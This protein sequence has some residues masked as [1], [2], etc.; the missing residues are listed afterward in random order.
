MCC[1][2]VGLLVAMGGGFHIAHMDEASDG[3]V[4]VSVDMPSAKD[5]NDRLETL[6]NVLTAVGQAADSEKEEPHADDAAETNEMTEYHT[7]AGYTAI[8]GLDVFR[9]YITEQDYIP[10]SDRSTAEECCNAHTGSIL[11]DGNW[12]VIMENI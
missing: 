11:Y 12:N 6:H 10:M 9:L 1:C 7:P 2:L 3:N 8:E 4:K 5:V